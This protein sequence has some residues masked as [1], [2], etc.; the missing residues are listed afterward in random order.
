MCT[1]RYIMTTQ[2]QNVNSLFDGHSK[3]AFGYSQS[4]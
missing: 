1:P 3:N 4:A 2:T